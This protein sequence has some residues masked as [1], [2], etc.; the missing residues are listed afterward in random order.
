MNVSEIIVFG[1]YHWRVLEVHED[2]MLLLTEDIIEKRPYHPV[3]EEVTWETCELR[4][5]LNHDFY[6]RFNDADKDRIITVTNTN[7][8]NPWYLTSGGADTEDKV[9]LLDIVDTVCKYFGDSSSKLYNKTPKE[10]YWFG[11]SDKNNIKRVAQ[12]KGY[13]YWWWVRT[14][15]RNLKTAVYIHGNPI[16]CVGINGNSVFFRSYTPERNG[17]VRPAMWVK[18]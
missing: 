10:R 1:D 6:N 5:Y 8:A 13:N 9:F 4:H 18:R 16:G 3:Y 12:Y 15:G 11:K 14:P 7:D 17:G 2:R